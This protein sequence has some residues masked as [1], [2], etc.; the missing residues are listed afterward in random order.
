MLADEFDL[1]HKNVFASVRPEKLQIDSL[2][3]H[4]SRSRF[5]PFRK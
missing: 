3:S 5:S 4:T 2:Q 1:S